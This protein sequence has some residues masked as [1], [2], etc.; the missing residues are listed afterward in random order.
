MINRLIFIIVFIIPVIAIW[1][2]CYSEELSILNGS[3]IK[4][5]FGSFAV[6]VTKIICTPLVAGL[7]VSGSIGTWVCFNKKGTQNA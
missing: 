4:Y 3:I 2:Y 6:E 5:G 1:G 7:L